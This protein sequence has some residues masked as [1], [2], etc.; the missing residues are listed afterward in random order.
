[1]PLILPVINPMIN[2][3]HT[4]ASTHIKAK[5]INPMIVKLN[6][7]R[8]LSSQNRGSFRDKAGIIAMERA[9]TIPVI[10][11]SGMEYMK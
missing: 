6:I 2:G 8:R 9:E 1:M 3:L 5:K 7:N 4:I 10:N 11:N